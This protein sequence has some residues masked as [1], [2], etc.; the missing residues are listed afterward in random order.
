MDR[1]YN[2]SPPPFRRRPS[3]SPESEVQILGRRI[4]QLEVP[5]KMNAPGELGGLGIAGRQLGLDPLFFQDAIDRFNICLFEG[6]QGRED[7]KVAHRGVEGT[8]EFLAHQRQ[9]RQADLRIQAL[10][11]KEP[12]FAPTPGGNDEERALERDGDVRQIL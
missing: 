4:A 1:L 8:G 10:A 2:R 5:G 9:A 7:V 12:R 3:R 11:Q 6:G